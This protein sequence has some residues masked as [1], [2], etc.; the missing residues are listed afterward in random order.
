MQQLQMRIVSLYVLFRC[1]GVAI[2]FTCILKGSD[3]YTCHK[4]KKSIL[5]SMQ[6]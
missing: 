2:V 4:S 3:T 1:V 6:D 5:N